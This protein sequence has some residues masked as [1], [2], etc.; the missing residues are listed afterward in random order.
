MTVMLLNVIS[1]TFGSTLNVTI[2][3]L[4]IINISKET[5]ILGSVLLA[6]AQYFL[7]IA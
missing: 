7:L 2:S 5:M 6:Q 4:L 1:V 3:I